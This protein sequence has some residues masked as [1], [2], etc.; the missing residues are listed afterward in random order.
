M[1]ADAKTESEVMSAL[2]KFT[3]AFGERN[4]EDL[5]MLFAPDL[6]VV[7]IGSGAGEKNVGM[8]EIKAF[9]KGLF[10][11]FEALSVEFGWT[12]VSKAGTVAWVA[13]DDTITLKAGGQET[14]EQ[15]RVTF[16]LD[17]RGDK[18]L[19]LQLHHSVPQ[20]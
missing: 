19:I 17:K 20:D 8:S 13:V 9:F 6:D 14:I 7:V 11:D 5:L 2:K 4:L 1:K 3:D 18:W 15:G 12:M 16:V 10:D